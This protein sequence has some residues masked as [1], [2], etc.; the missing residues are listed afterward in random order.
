MSSAGWLAVGL[1]IPSLAIAQSTQSGAVFRDCAE[2]PEVVVVPA[3]NFTMGSTPQETALA[4][5]P[6]EQAAREYPAHGVVISRPFAIGRYEI[7]V[8]EYE[9]FAAA[10]DRPASKNCTTWD[11]EKGIWGPLGNADWRN[12]GYEQ[13]GQHPVGCLTIDDARAY[14]AWLS[15]KTGKT[16]R[17]P[18]EAE[19]EY[20]ARAGT[21]TMQT[22]SDSFDNICA[23]ANVA[24]QTRV[25]AHRISDP[26]PTRFFPCNDDFVYA[27]PVGRFPPNPWG[28]YDMIGNIWEWT[29]D[30]FIPTYDGAP[31]D[32][33]A[34]TEPG[35]TRLIV[36][37]GGWYSRTWFARNA[38]R[39][40]EDLSYRSS[41]L[42]LRVVRELD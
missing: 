26:D 17:V 40:R 12:P 27:A 6:Q 21:T 29:E 37:G 14:V 11:I 35:C 28:L 42:G 19:W 1:I 8:D 23:F 2:C 24:D 13:S 31:T 22:W 30:C 10:T 4:G 32:G 9:A 34:R 39:S 20:V 18:S 25:A 5:L 38:G 36:R 33:T 15:K 7:T 16:Y 41:T 3:G